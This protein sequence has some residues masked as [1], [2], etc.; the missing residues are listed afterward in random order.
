MRAA[1]AHSYREHSTLTDAEAGAEIM[2]IEKRDTARPHR[3]CRRREGHFGAPSPASRTHYDARCEVSA[4]SLA[5][6]PCLCFSVNALP[7]SLTW[8]NGML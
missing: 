1:F 8:T 4:V 2:T 6:R 5:A 7:T 3:R